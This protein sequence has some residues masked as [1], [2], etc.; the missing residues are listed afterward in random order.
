VQGAL[1]LVVELFFEADFCDG[2]YGYRPKRRA[3]EAVVRVSKVVVE[4]KTMVIDL[5]LESHFDNIV[6]DILFSK[7]AQRVD[8]D[9]IMRLAK[10]ILKASGKKGVPQGGVISPLL[11]N[12]YL[13]EVDKMLEKAK[14]VT[15]R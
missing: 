10:M 3:H 5:D 4:N 2:S 1:R 11:A 7:V 6:H 8:D 14:K 12:V 13:N 9:K 15:K